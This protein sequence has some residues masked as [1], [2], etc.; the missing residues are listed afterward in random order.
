MH[1][2]EVV[3]VVATIVASG[4]AIARSMYEPAEVRSGAASFFGLFMKITSR[5]ALVVFLICAALLA[6]RYLGFRG[7]FPRIAI[8]GLAASAVV[9]VISAGLA[10]AAGGGRDRQRQ[11][12]RRR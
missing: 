2:F 10:S 5:A 3:G 6:A 4:F 12:Q 1:W 8:A 7:V 11:S 9:F